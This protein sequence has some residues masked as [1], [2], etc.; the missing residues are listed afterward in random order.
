MAIEFDATTITIA[1]SL[2]LTGGESSGQV[3]GA[4]LDSTGTALYI[5]AAATASE[6]ATRYWRRID[7]TNPAVPTGSDWLPSYRE[8]P[9]DANNSDTLGDQNVF[10]HDP[11]TGIVWVFFLSWSAVD[12]YHAYLAKIDLPSGLVEF[13][14]QEFFDQDNVRYDAPVR[15]LVVVG[16]TMYILADHRNTTE[17]W[18]SKFSLSGVTYSLDPNDIGSS[19]TVVATTDQRV[20][21]NT[22]SN[23]VP[24]GMTKAADGHLL[25]LYDDAG[26]CEKYNSTTLSYLGNTTWSA[27]DVGC[28]FERAGFIWTLNDVGAGEN[29]VLTKFK[30]ASTGVIS[31]EHTRYF[32]DDR[33]IRINEPLHVTLKVEARDGFGAVISTLVGKSARFEVLT[34]RG[35]VDN[36]DLALST[37][38]S[39]TNS[40][41]R[42][43]NGTPLNRTVFAPFNSSGV[44]TAYAQSARISEADT[45][46]DRVRASYP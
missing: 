26:L 3:L 10:F 38:N 41:F 27:S 37:V 11:T 28:L 23:R 40:N 7:I 19:G 8:L 44:A 18:L 32:G 46:T 13:A 43:V 31:Q 39:T 35:P 34:N 30:D 15:G 16:S 29:F 21:L 25:V 42:D 45:V 5:L 14:H 36:D 33:Q 22:Q 1:R 17:A 20:V 6:N 24:V 4:F 2:V 12:G 9:N